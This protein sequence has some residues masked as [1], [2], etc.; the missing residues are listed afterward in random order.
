MV[1]TK[2]NDLSIGG[3][4][5][6]GWIIG[7]VKNGRK[8]EPVGYA[9]LPAMCPIHFIARICAGERETAVPVWRFFLTTSQALDAR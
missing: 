8:L 2:T 6:Q 4:L 7:A 3:L 9:D 5:S 1:N